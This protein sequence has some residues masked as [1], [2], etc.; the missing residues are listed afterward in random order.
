MGMFNR[1]YFLPQ[2]KVGVA[3]G[4]SPTQI[5]IVASPTPGR[6]A[7]GFMFQVTVQ[8][9]G[10]APGTARGIS[11]VIHDVQIIPNDGSDPTSLDGQ[12]LMLAGLDAYNQTQGILSGYQAWADTV[13]AATGVA[14]TAQY[15]VVGP[16][17]GTGFTITFNI[18]AATATGYTSPSAAA[19]T[20]TCVVIEADPTNIYTTD[21]KSI[22]GFAQPDQRY[23]L[24]GNYIVNS[25]YVGKALTN[26]AI[27]GLDNKEL[28]TVVSSIKC[29]GNTYS[30][31]QSQMGE[32]AF[33]GTIPN[34]VTFGTAFAGNATLPPKNPQ[35]GNAVG[36]AEYGG[37]TPANL[38]ISLQSSQT[39][40]ILQRV[41]V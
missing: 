1:F 29:G 10:T 37:P 23:K 26:D 19:Y 27:I 30:A 41:F 21:G 38:E 7:V 4:T 25:T 35:T 34:G 22:S 39:M 16:F 31:Q 14:A 18:N 24:I 8:I 5:T 2:S 9:T 17:R 20:V 12:T 33:D 6:V 32:D 13:T 3:S 28:G 40:L 15:S 11:Q 36:V